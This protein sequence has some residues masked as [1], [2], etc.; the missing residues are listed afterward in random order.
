MALVYLAG[1]LL[2]LTLAIHGNLAAATIG[3]G[4]WFL[5][6]VL[7]TPTLKLYDRPALEGLGLP[8]AGLLYTGMTLDSALRH[9]QGRGGQWKGRR[10]DARALTGGGA[11]SDPETD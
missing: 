10:Y 6:P 7:Y 11:P 8:L 2:A 9:W 5:M 4:T 1:P 3:M